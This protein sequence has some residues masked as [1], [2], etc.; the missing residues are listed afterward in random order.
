M[1]FK[2]LQRQRRRLLRAI[3]NNDTNSGLGNPSVTDT[4]C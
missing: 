2:E 1:S 4:A 3:K